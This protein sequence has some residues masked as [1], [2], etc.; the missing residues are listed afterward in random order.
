MVHENCTEQ[1]MMRVTLTTQPLQWVIPTSMSTKFSVALNSLISWVRLL[2]C[3][4]GRKSLVWYIVTWQ[5]CWRIVIV[6]MT[7]RDN[8]SVSVCL[9]MSSVRHHSTPIRDHLSLL[10]VS[11]DSLPDLPYSELRKN[12]KLNKSLI[13]QALSIS[14]YWCSVRL[15]YRNCTANLI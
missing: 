6:Q 1:S 9:L 14:V 12:K 13:T 15:L 8:C 4:C 2:C 7:W 3:Y 10:D 11:H 5:C